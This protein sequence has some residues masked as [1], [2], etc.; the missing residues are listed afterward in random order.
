MCFGISHDK[1]STQDYPDMDEAHKWD[2]AMKM[3]V[4]TGRNK[5]LQVGFHQP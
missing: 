2:K 3:L 1:K 4:Y 5:F